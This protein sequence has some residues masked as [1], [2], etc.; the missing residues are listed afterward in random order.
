[1]ASDEK[2]LIRVSQEGIFNIGFSSVPF[3]AYSRLEILLIEPS[4]DCEVDS[5]STSCAGHNSD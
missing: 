3:E 4:L 1:M 2:A 5:E